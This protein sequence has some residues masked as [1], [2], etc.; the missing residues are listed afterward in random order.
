M[1]LCLIHAFDRVD[2]LAYVSKGFLQLELLDSLFS[3]HLLIYIL[4]SLDRSLFLVIRGN[5]PKT[6]VRMLISAKNLRLS[7]TISRVN[8]R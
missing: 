2:K 4:P 5:V 1:K 3:E 7:T 8:A 6:I